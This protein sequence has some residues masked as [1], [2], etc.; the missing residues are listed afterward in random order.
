MELNLER[1]IALITGGSKG[2]GLAIKQALEKEGVKI[3]SLSRTEGT[4]LMD[5]NSIIDYN[6]SF[7]ILINN[8]GGMGTCKPKDWMDAMYKNYGLMVQNTMK[9]LPY[10]EE[11]NWGRIITISSIY[12]KEKGTNPFFTAAKAA[13]IAFMKSMAGKYKG[14]TFNTIAPGHIDVGKPFPY[15]PNKIGQPKD[16]ADLVTFFCSDL[17][18]HIDGAC[19]TVDG[20]ESYSY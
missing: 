16:V 15:E 12:G 6:A 18:K 17:A 13:Q 7:D 14:I 4:D 9:C 11:N 20:G 3:H 1:K 19:I 2:I 5:P 8:I 10:M